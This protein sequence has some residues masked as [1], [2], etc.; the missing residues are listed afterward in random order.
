MLL[1][2]IA[3]FGCLFLVFVT[4]V[5]IYII[6]DRF[7]ASAFAFDVERIENLKT[8]KKEIKIAGKE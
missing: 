4:G 3:F 8:A 6:K 1:N 7:G 5:I 2:L